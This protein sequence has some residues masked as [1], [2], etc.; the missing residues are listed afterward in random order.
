MENSDTWKIINKMFEGNPQSLVRHH[1]ESYNDFYKTGIFQIFKEKNP[2]RI[3]T[4]YDDKIDDFRSQCIMHFGGKDGDKIYFGKPVIYDNNDSHYM[5]PNEARLRNMTYGMT[6]HYDI[7]VEFIDILEEGEAPS[8][9]GA[10]DLDLEELEPI[11]EGGVGKAPKRKGKSKKVDLELTPG[12]LSELKAATMKTMSDKNT[13]KRT[14]TLEK[15][16]L[17]KFPIMMQSNYCVL[18]GLPKEVRHSMGECSNDIGGYFVIDGKEKTVVSQEKFGDNMLYIRKVGDEKYLYSAEIRSVSENVSKPMRTMSVKIKTPTNKYTFNNIVVNIP[19]VRSPVPLF[20][21]FRALGFVS[22]KEIITMCL[23][24]IDKYE[25]MMDLFIPSVHDAGGILTQRNALK[26]IALLTKG[27]TVPHAQEILCDYFLPHIGEN[28]FKQKAYYLGYIVFRLLSVHTGNE[29]PTD[30]DNCKYK[31]IELVGNLMYDLFREYYTIQQRTIHLEFEKRA[32]YNQS[33]YAN[34]L[35]GLIQQ[36][37]KEIFRERI[38]ETGFKKAFKGNWGSQS[39][40]KRIGVVQDLNRLSHNSVLSHLRKTNLPLD[41]TAKVVGP[42]V[43]HSTH[44]GFFDPIDTPDGGNIGLHKHLSIGAYITQGY[45]NKYMIDWMR[46]KVDMKLI[47]DCKPIILS[48]MTKVIINGLWIGAITEPIE[49]V[50]K[51]KLYRRNGLIPIYTSISFDINLNALFIYTDAG[52]ICRPI[53][54]KDEETN[55]MSFAH[56][57]NMKRIADND[58]TW[59]NLITGFNE[60]KISTFRPNGNKL[61]E[62]SDLYDNIDSETNPAKLKRFL[63]DKA[64]IDYIDTN[65]TESAIIA[66]NK[67]ALDKKKH[68]YTHMEIHESLIFGTMTNLINYPENNPATR[69]SFSCG[70]SKQACSMYHTNHQVRMDKTAVVLN[71]GQNPLVKSRYLEH[72]NNEGNPYGENTIVAVMCY[73]GYNVEDAILVNEGALKRGLF[74]TTYYSTYETHEEK[75]KMGNSTT[76]KILLNIESDSSVVGTKE[77]YDYSKLDKYGIVKENTELN[78][79]TVIIGMA[80]YD[81]TNPNNKTDM[82]KG[83][84]KGQI[85]IVDKTFITEGEEGTRIAKVRVR[86]ERIPN[87]GDKM[88]SRAG[89]KGTVGLVIP[90]VDMPFSKNGI[91]PDLIINPHAIPSRMT[92]GQFVETITGKA[93]AMYGSFGDCTAYNNNGSKVGVFGEMLTKVGYHSSGNELLYNGMTGEQLETEIFMGPNYYMR[94]KHMVKDK[95]NYRARGPRT[96]LTKQPVSGRAND[97]G[98]RIGEMERDSIISHGATEF[99]RESLMERGDKYQMAI[100]NTSGMMSIYNPSKNVF[101]SPMADGPIKY[102]GSLDDKSM[103][104]DTISQFGRNFSIVQVPYSLKLLM[105]ELL[106]INISMR[107]I[108]EDNIEQLENMSFSKNIDLLLHSKDVNVPS[109]IKTIKDSLIDQS[110]MR[111]PVSIESA[112]K[113]PDYNPLS[114]YNNYE[115]TDDN[116]T[117]EYNPYTPGSPDYPP[118]SPGYNPNSPGYPTNSPGYP[119]NSPGYP[120]NSPNYPPNSPDYPTNSPGTSPNSP[121]PKKG[122]L[123]DTPDSDDDS[124]IPPPPSK[125]KS[126]ESNDEGYNDNEIVHYRGD[127]MPERL[128]KITKMGDQFITIQTDDSRGL[129]LF[130]MTKVV[131]LIDIYKQGDYP[132]S[133]PYSSA[134]PTAEPYDS[135]PTLKPDSTTP[136]INFQPVI[137]INTGTSKNTN[138]NIDEDDTNGEMVAPG[139]KV[140]DDNFEKVSKPTNL[141]TGGIVVKKSL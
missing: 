71:S 138:A 57:N 9:I 91:R 7:D 102:T 28:N 80:S 30:R 59:D 109:I 69:N 33:I 23:L 89:Q 44:W 17:G 15:I 105:Q 45:S 100:C 12:E 53:F 62:L 13:Q 128:W 90:E 141:F 87:L 112:E 1:I 41:P 40:T 132:Y 61:Y 26:Y 2:I 27:K 29:E 85:G 68:D 6:I 82:S 81:E 83:T 121:P 92:I 96:A 124:F 21:V 50:S 58:F 54:Y 115:Q 88:A 119:T 47:E 79:K 51:F 73:T 43:L 108:T 10:E 60:K 125:N 106:T 86:E 122:I 139:I 35:Y 70:Q 129:E 135:V 11:V 120:T 75:S 3:Q 32:H 5:F 133:S 127:S 49:T 116:Q 64:V 97:G 48:T 36:N 42:R 93:C 104:I 95:I 123:R 46:E 136:V 14:I 77:G 103:H 55:Q 56:K 126:I 38:V 98:L 74:R 66:I 8:I 94:L 130:D 22:D 114:P 137:S 117:P 118:N 99:L 67:D 31:R 18:A 131:S 113:T 101:L 4:R 78:D 25:N 140:K 39:H 34:N 84:K 110:D 16:L 111:T 20:I 52:R 24:D 107:I 65:E 134:I 72:I 37:Y 19:N 63:E 76:Q